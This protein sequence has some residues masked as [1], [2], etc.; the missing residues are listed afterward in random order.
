M[1]GSKR[2]IEQ[3]EGWELEILVVVELLVVA[4]VQW[5][6]KQFNEPLF[7]FVLFLAW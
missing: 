7:C 6:L 3:R 4:T 5:N 1:M 2:V